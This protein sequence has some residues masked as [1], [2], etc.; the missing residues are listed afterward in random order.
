MFNK[1]I[2]GLRYIFYFPI[3]QLKLFCYL[4]SLDDNLTVN[5]I[6]INAHEFKTKLNKKLIYKTKSNKG[7]KK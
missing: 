2:I 1:F 3:I 6:L 7:V 5:E 4:K